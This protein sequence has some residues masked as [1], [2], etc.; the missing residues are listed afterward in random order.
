LGRRLLEYEEQR[1]ESTEANDYL[2]KRGITKEARDY[3]RIGFVAKPVTPADNMFAG[4]LVIPYLT[5]SGPVAMKFRRVT[6]DESAKYLNFRG[7]N[8]LRPFNPTS[9]MSSPETVYVCE[10]EIDTITMHIIGLPAIGF[11]GTDLVPWPETEKFIAGR[12][13]VVCQDGDDTGAGK[14]FAERMA[15]LTGDGRI[16]VF[17]GTD[18]NGYYQMNG[19]DALKRKVTEDAT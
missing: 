5:V 17:D 3:F 16:V 4:R 8:M 9:L 1:R 2:S 7:S 19:G 6:D 11:G 14:R 10:G 18:V 13:V 15:R 12:K